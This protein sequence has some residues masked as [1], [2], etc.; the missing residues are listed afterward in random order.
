MKPTD[1]QTPNNA[2]TPPNN[3]VSA[4]QPLVK[5]G[6]TTISTETTT[7]NNSNKVNI[8]EK[9]KTKFNSYPK[10]VKIL[11]VVVVAF[12]VIIFFLTILAAMFGK[13]Q[14]VVYA[15]P[16]P[17]PISG[18]P[19]PEVILNASRYATDEGVLKIESELKD[20]QKQLDSSDV[21]Q[22]DLSIPSLDFDVN[23]D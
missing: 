16:T 1:T 8:P 23:F 13:K 14:Q 22:T 15:T 7:S 11:I 21:K 12:F 6:S 18:S 20:F 17:S 3:P 10:N 2:V 4:N 5:S 19:Q 9:L